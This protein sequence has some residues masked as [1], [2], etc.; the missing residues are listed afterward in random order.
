MKIFK[1]FTIALFI[2]FSSLTSITYAESLK[3]DSSTYEGEIKKGK[4]HGRGVLKYSNGSK[5][6]G[7]FQEGKCQGQG[8]LTCC[9]GTTY[10]G[11]WVENHMHGRGKLI[12]YDYVQDG[13]WHMSEYECDIGDEL[14]PFNYVDTK[15]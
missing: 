6:V 2:I 15:K 14:E 7:E 9:D 10:E 13:F 12:S 5:Y 1:L 11:E 8:M 4:P 3:F